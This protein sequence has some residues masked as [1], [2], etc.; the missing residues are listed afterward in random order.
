M[1]TTWPVYRVFGSFFFFEN[2]GFAFEN[3]GCPG[4]YQ[5]VKLVLLVTSM[6]S[7]AFDFF[8]NFPTQVFDYNATQL[9]SPILAYVL[10]KSFFKTF[11]LFSSKCFSDES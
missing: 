2:P 8:P 3:S 5:L 11:P 4:F 9:L 1:A 10:M 7:L 6:R